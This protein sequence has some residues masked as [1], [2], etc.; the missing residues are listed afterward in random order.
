MIKVEQQG[1]LDKTLDVSVHKDLYSVPHDGAEEE[2]EEDEEAAPPQRPLPGLVAQVPEEDDPQQ[3]P[4]HGPGDVGR[5]GDEVVLAGVPVVDRHPG[6]HS[7]DQEEPDEP[8][9]GELHLPPVED[10]VGQLDDDQEGP[11]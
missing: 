2:A 7:G 6:V 10:H 8:E 9:G 11:G 1:S 3:E 5:V 4:H